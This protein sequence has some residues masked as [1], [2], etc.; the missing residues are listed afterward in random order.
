VEGGGGLYL[1]GMS[2]FIPLFAYNKPLQLNR[3]KLPSECKKK[4]FTIV[5]TAR[6]LINKVPHHQCV[7]V[8]KTNRWY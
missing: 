5:Y 4:E 8:T 1:P 3:T 6:T 7:Y 2:E